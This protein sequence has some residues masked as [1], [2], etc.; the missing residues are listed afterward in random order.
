MMRKFVI[1]RGPI[2]WLLWLLGAVG[3]TMPWGKVYMRE[4]WFE[5][6]LTRLHEVVHLRQIQRDGAV[7][8]T[9]RYLWWQVRYGYWRNPYEVEAYAI[10]DQAR[11]RRGMPGMPRLFVRP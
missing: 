2:A 6:R 1:A 4:P 8:F 10:E 7:L 9:L 3:I 5:D 11:A